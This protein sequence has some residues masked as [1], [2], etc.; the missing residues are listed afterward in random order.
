[1]IAVA[2]LTETCRG[3]R[4]S[5]IGNREPRRQ[6][7]P[8]EHPVASDRMSQPGSDKQRVG[9]DA[10][11]QYAR[12]QADRKATGVISAKPTVVTGSEDATM[13]CYGCWISL[14]WRAC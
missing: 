11:G 2:G 10:R 4:L 14:Q 13:A 6:R 7:R 12:S 1:M 9:Q 3:Y 5:A 8:G